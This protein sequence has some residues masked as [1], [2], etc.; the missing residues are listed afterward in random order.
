MEI[1]QSIQLRV[2]DSLVLNEDLEDLTHPPFGFEEM[3]EREPELQR[4]Q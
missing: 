3:F 4:L 2:V 1:S